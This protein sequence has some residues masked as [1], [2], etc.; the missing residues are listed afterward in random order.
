MSP[1]AAASLETAGHQL[2]AE[3]RYA[4]AIGE[5]REAVEASGGSVARCAEP[6]SAACLTFAYALYDLGSAVRL[7]G[8][9]GAAVPILSERLRIDN[10]RAVV[11]EQLDLAR[12]GA[13]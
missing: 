4:Q 8:D 11:E 6:T 13:A 1:A 10:Q 2:L 9:P 7:G 3:G 5:L 12:A